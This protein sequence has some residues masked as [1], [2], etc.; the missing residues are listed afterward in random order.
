[1]LQYLLTGLAGIAVGIVAMRLWQMR[2]APPPDADGTPGEAGVIDGLE[3]VVERT[4]V[5]YSR[6]LLI[7][8]AILVAF[9]IAFFTFRSPED[10]PTGNIASMAGPTSGLDD[11]DSMIARLAKRLEDNPDDGEG[12]R[13]LG[14]SYV[15]TDRP[16]LAIEPY[17]K[18]LA[19]IPDNPVVHSGYGEALVGMAD[20]KVTAEA[21]A[22][23]EKALTLDSGEPRSRYFLAM[24]QAQNGDEKEAL[25]KW[26]A[27]ANSGPADAPWQT[28]LRA[29]IAKTST[30]LG[31]DVSG[32]IDEAGPSASASEPPVLDPATVQ[33]ANAM[34]ESDRQAMIENM[35]EGLA[36]KLR[37]NP[38]DAGGWERLFRSRMVLKQTEQAGKD[39]QAARKALAG[40][41]QVLGRVNA[42]A[43]ELGVPGAK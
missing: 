18:A 42:I 40:S 24:W 29:Q 11:V 7:G 12:F 36:A 19:L 9:S 10:G 6:L 15:M 32:R 28:D 43:R 5:P 13:M 39:L 2:E 1:M 34:S 17:K 35:V 20:G 8:A 3:Q 14:W 37:A 22:S 16:E 31:V 41:P 30:K 21:K 26:I 25:E 33:A 23:F 38:A 4:P 27:L